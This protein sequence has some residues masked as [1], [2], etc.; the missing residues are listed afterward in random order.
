MLRSNGGVTPASPAGIVTARRMVDLIEKSYGDHI[1]VRTVSTS[2]GGKPGKLGA[3]FRLITGSSV[4][5]YVTR[6]RLG[7]AAHL[8]RSNL[9]IESVALSVGYRSKKN[10]Y[11]QFTRHF[12]VT[13]DTYRRRRGVP[14]GKGHRAGVRPS[15]GAE[16][17]MTTYAGSFDETPCVIDVEPRPNVK[18]RH[19]Y[20][21]TPFV[22]FEHGL[23]PFA[24]SAH[25]EISGETEAEALER[26]SVFLEHRFGPRRTLSPRP[27]I[28]RR[29][30]ILAAR[31]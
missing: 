16:V 31:R 23:Q 21:A 25:V 22:K 14:E 26:C 18:G 28:E 8:I 9:K 11:R 2:L 15:A 29:P 20:I 17:G 7:H 13:P 19:S 3:L 5:A 6:V 1:T 10:F 30:P 12:G 4:H 24:W 27:A